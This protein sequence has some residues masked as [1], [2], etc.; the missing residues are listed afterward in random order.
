MKDPRR[1]LDGDGTDEQRALLRAGALEEPG[2]EGRARLLAALGVAPPAPGDGSPEL[3]SAGDA[4]LSAGGAATTG[5]VG[6]TKLAVLAVSSAVLIGAGALLWSRGE[7]PVAGDVAAGARTN[8]TERAAPPQEDRD[9][10]EQSGS[11]AL[12]IEA[13]ERVRSELGRK[14]GSAALAA[15]SRYSSA[16]PHGVLAH[17]ADVLRVEA[18]LLEG[19]ATAARELSEHLL[20]THGDSP[21]R[22]R[23]QALARQAGAQPSP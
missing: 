1:L 14:D 10:S 5:A 13:L 19:E 8:P 20:R 15:L 18:L 23:L 4:G 7:P 11:V 2:T 3:Q 21:H 9:S 16:H 22:A 17:E 6:A 12:E